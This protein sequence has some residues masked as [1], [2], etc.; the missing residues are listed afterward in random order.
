M[1]RRETT[2]LNQMNVY[3]AMVGSF[4]SKKKMPSSFPPVS[5]AREKKSIALQR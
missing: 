1:T 4:E 3:I 2:V 5:A